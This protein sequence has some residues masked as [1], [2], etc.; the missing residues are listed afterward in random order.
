MEARK[1]S[2][3]EIENL[4]AKTAENGKKADLLLKNS[5]V[6][7]DKITDIETEIFG[8]TEEADDAAGRRERE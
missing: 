4:L 8:Y 1:A 7:A 6:L 3:N 2:L 5:S